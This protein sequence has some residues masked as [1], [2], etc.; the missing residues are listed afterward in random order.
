MICG[1]STKTIFF[2]K[3][4]CVCLSVCI[5]HKIH[6]LKAQCVSIPQQMSHS[7]EFAILHIHLAKCVIVC[8]K[9][10]KRCFFTIFTWN[11]NSL[12]FGFQEILDWKLFLL[13]LNVFSIQH[14]QCNLS[15]IKFDTFFPLFFFIVE[16]HSS[17]NLRTSKLFALSTE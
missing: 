3:Q 1:V 13:A 7:I 4:I 9:L 6:L 16:I 10:W 11:P 8:Y 15:L 14:G 17:V 12:S 5:C 2:A